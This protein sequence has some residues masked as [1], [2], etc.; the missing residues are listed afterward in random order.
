[1][2]KKVILIVL[3]LFAL[4]GGLLFAGIG[5]AALA[6]GGR[7][8]TIQSGYHHLDTS[9]SAFVTDPAHIRDNTNMSVRTGTATTLR[10]AARNTPQNLFIGVGPSDQVTAY[11]N[12]T[13]YEE[14]TN[15]D[16]SPFQLTTNQVVGT[17]EPAAPGDQS[18]WVAS[19]A[20]SHPSLNF[21]LSNGDYRV[22]VM[23]VDGSPGVVADVRVGIKVP[24]LFGVGLGAAIGGTLVALLGLGLLIWGIAAKRKPAAG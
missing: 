9:T 12:G 13:S 7:S 4:L 15:I 1:M 5:A 23:N 6:L 20:G 19:A 16:F 18:F 22:V 10:I 8:G 3:G 21:N 14:I 24:A 2:V 17:A 11:L